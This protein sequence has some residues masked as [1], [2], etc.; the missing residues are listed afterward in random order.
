[1]NNQ[2]RNRLKDLQK[3]INVLSEDLQEICNEE[4]S[5]YENMP[6]NLQGSER[7][8][9]AV[10]AVDSLNEIISNLY[11]MDNQIDNLI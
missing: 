7:Y 8:E 10:E 11:D 6:E 4:E 1:M 2:R 9:N 3:M 5:Y